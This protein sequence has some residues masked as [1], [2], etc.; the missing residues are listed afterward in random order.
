MLKDYRVYPKVSLYSELILS[1]LTALLEIAG[2]ARE[3][4]SKYGLLAECIPN[5]PGIGD[6]LACGLIFGLCN[7]LKWYNYGEPQGSVLRPTLWNV[8]MDDLLRMPLP[9]GVQMIAYA[10][11]LSIMI[12][13]IGD[14]SESKARL[15]FLVYAARD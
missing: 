5:V 4:S 3:A 1:R 6:E 12:G 2:A 7:I 9:D 8:L 15:I 10:N 13:P 14:C 11:Y